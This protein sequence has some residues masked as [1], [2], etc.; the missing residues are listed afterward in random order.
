MRLRLY[1]PDRTLIDAPVNKVIAEAEDGSFCLLPRHI[2]FVALLVPGILSYVRPESGSEEYAAVDEGILVKCGGDVSVS[3]RK[4]VLSGDLGTLRRTVEKE[5][6]ELDDQ[7]R[8]ARSII[9]RLESDFLR[10]TLGL[11]PS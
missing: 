8:K 4:A 9:A 11:R 3:T 2:D 5:F 1:L 6:E 7:E 10:G